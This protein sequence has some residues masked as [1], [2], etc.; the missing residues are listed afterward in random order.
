M[1]KQKT[2]Y[3]CAEC[4]YKSPKWLGR[5]SD[6]GSFNSLSEELV[7][8]NSHALSAAAAQTAVNLTKFNEVKQGS[9]ERISTKIAEFDRVLS[10]GF[11][12]GSVV[13]LGGE[14]GIGKSTLLLQ[15]CQS[16]G[17]IGKKVLYVSG[18]ESAEQIKMRGER[19]KITTDNLYL[20]PETSLEIVT[21]AINKLSPDFLIIDS[22]QTMQTEELTGSPGSV[23]QVRECTMSLMEMAKGMN[24][25][26]IIVGHVTKEGSIAG[27]KI[28]EHIVDT[29]LYF[30]GDRREM[31]RIIRTVKNRFGATN[32]IGVFE[33][34]DGGLKEIKNPSEY[35]LSGRP[36]NV[37]GSAVTC[38]VEGTRP[39]LAEVQA[40]VT[41]TNYGM[42]RR[43]V[44]GIDP[45][46]VAMMLAVLEKKT[47]MQLGSFDSYVNIAGGMR[48]TEPAVDAAALA[49]VASNYR[50]KAIDPKT[51]IFGEVGLAGE[52]RAVH[53]ADARI[54]EAAR[55]GFTECV[56]PVANLKGIKRVDGI[57]LLGAG[58]VLEML[59]AVLG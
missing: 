2:T 48:I 17:G 8:K 18:E 20:L 12:D 15:I 9:Y 6:C 33:M 56:L 11:V 3:I 53:M 37:S 47:G 58:D 52:I 51:M 25:P 34:T 30:E 42:A 43:N 23:S 22:I 50:N 7:V 19:L 40:L 24:I 26:T 49:A 5:C 57:R 28:L 55:M 44:T 21:A 45:N 1:P 32:E 14:P 35:M 31:Y 54:M 27:P 36:L 16:I 39:I 13:L 41:Q 29:V 10:G 46:R 4:G 59:G 38:A